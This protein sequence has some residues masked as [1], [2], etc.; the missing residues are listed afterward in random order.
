MFFSKP[1][2]APAS[3]TRVAVIGTSPLAFFLADVLQNNCCAVTILMAANKL[4]TYTRRSSLNVKLSNFQNRHAS[5]SFAAKLDSAADFVF[6]AS[7]PEDSRN[8]LLLLQDPLL[9]SAPLINLSSFYNRRIISQFNKSDIPA[10]F[11]GWLNLEKNSLHL[12]E[13]SP[14]LELCCDAETAVTI[15][16]LFADSPVSLTFPA[17]S[18]N[19]FWQHL[20]PFLLG[21]LLVL[22]AGRD[23]SSVLLQN[24]IRRQT[25]TAVNE[26]CK[27]AKAEKVSLD[28]ANILPRLYAFPDN[29]QSEFSSPQSFAALSALIPGINRFDTPA[30]Y[31]FLANA[32]KKY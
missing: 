23:I 7:S 2:P 19:L 10:Y 30:L 16:A 29:Y 8:D 17:P 11:N 5:F 4:N 12:L 9:K 31:G 32:A 24:D 21:N 18:P 13:R 22:S 14:V 28:P 25:D 1:A 6:I 27:L 3:L 15:K 26:L 20:A